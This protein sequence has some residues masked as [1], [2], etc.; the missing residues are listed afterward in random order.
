M[1]KYEF[2]EKNLKWHLF[3]LDIS[4]NYNYPHV[5]DTT[6]NDEFD[7]QHTQH[8]KRIFVVFD[9]IRLIWSW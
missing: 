5:V 7:C 1:N 2:I 9:R 8:V 6:I 4:S 3:D